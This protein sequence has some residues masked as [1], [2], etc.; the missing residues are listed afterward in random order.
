MKTAIVHFRQY[1]ALGLDDRIVMPTLMQVMH[2]I[3]PSYFNVF[4][5]ADE[6][7]EVSGFHTENPDA[8]AASRRYMMEFANRRELKSIAV[9]FRQ[10][11]H[12]REVRNAAHLG[13]ALYKSDFYG[14]LLHPLGIR[15]L[16]RGAVPAGKN[17]G[18]SIM[19][20]R[21]P[22]EKPFNANE[23]RRLA[24]LLPYLAHACAVPR[25]QGEPEYIDSGEDEGLLLVNMRGRMEYSNEQGR[26]FMRMA[27]IDDPSQDEARL[28]ARL[29]EAVKALEATRHG[30]PA[31]P[32]AFVVRSGWG[33]FRFRLYGMQSNDQG[34]SLVC[35][36]I[37]R[38]VPKQIKQLRTIQS[39]GLS[40]RLTDY[41]QALSR[42]L[43]HAEAARL[44]GITLNTAKGYFDAIREKLDIQDREALL[45][46]ILAG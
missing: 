30:R 22:G 23:E 46:R 45:R 38:Q 25:H 9:S 42:G 43:T 8:I 13:S 14:E 41:C 16:I 7:K 26:L 12:D 37:T 2:R 19:L 4:W 21:A 24:T 15:T 40:P 1:C 32:P 33:M 3:I 18:G 27:V 6:N 35:V 39:F 11:M 10:H 36:W 20:T 31:P 44:L 17:G 28:N 5:W 29:A 34:S